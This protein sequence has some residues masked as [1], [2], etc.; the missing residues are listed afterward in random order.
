MDEL[1]LQTVVEKLEEIE[2][3]VKRNNQNKT[4]AELKIIFE[5]IRNLSS[6]TISSEIINELIKNRNACTNKL[7]ASLQNTIEHRHH[8]HKGLWIALTLF[9]LNIFLL[10]GWINSHNKVR[11]FRANDFK[12]RALKTIEDESLKKVLSNIDSLYKMDPEYFEKKVIKREEIFYK[13]ARPIIKVQAVFTNSQYFETKPGTQNLFKPKA[14]L[15]SVYAIKEP[16]AVYNIEDVLTL[17]SQPKTE[18]KET[19]ICY[20]L[21][22]S[23][24]HHLLPFLIPRLGKFSKA[25]DKIKVFSNFLSGIQKNMSH[26]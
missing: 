9:I 25:G 1:L 10:I 4:E 14:N 12:Y 2:L 21:M 13:E 3:L 15:G 26:H 11:E 18:T 8:L 19:T 24:R 20:V 17:P 6:R 22:V 16:L 23:Q 5:E 7:N